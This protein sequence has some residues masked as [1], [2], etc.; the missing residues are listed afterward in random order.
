[1]ASAVASVV[2]P[3]PINPE[4]PAGREGGGINV[5]MSVKQF[6]GAS[7][8]TSF[9]FFFRRIYCKPAWYTT[10]KPTARPR[11]RGRCLGQWLDRI[12]CYKETI[13]ACFHAHAVARKSFDRYVFL[14]LFIFF[15]FSFFVFEH[16]ESVST[17][18]RFFQPSSSGLTA[19]VGFDPPIIL[20]DG[21]WAQ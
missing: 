14:A 12:Y 19:A 10:V 16:R 2:F 6:N 21:R 4:I 5:I 8:V 17:A 15:L 13:R 11:A 3:A 20:L 1:M 7:S 18:R 9:F